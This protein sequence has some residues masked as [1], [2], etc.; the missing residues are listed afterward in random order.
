M[1]NAKYIAGLLL[2]YF[3]IINISYATAPAEP[4]TIGVI[5]YP[6]FYIL[7][8]NVQPTG[9]LANIVTQSF[10]NADVQ[11]RFASF[12]AKRLL[13]NLDNGHIQ[14]FAGTVDPKSYGTNVIYS[15]MIIYSVVV[16][17]Y[18]RAGEA[19]PQNIEQLKQKRLG[20]LAGTTYGKIR[21][22][23]STPDNKN[24]LTR[25][26]SYRSGALMLKK[27][28]I[29]LFLAYKNS[30]DLTLI[31]NPVEGLHSSILQQMPVYF[32]LNKNMPGA[33][34]LMLRLETGFKKF[35]QQFAQQPTEPQTQDSRLEVQ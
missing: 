32:I 24:Y 2:L 3:S 6:P 12:P 7:K 27:G 25:I 10:I 23:L 26:N 34:Q 11:F 33:K 19:L 22:R 31:Q 16:Q 35:A 4:I 8:K 1:Q 30:M 13:H 14:F 21:G 5:H 15:Q 17:V 29:D 9:I 28:H 20:L 18:G